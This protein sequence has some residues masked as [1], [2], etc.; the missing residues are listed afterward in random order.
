MAKR[1][2]LD[3]NAVI[4]F[5]NETEPFFTPLKKAILQFKAS[6]AEFYTSTIT[7]AEYMV[8]PLSENQFDKI[9]NYADF[10][11]EFE[12]QRLY[13]NEVV[14]RRS[15]EI[16]AKYRGIKLADALQLAASI[17]NECSAFLTNDRQLSQVNEAN[18]V[19][20]SDLPA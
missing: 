9:I 3:T 10:I 16:R 12:F 11:R 20:I 8:K 5:L 2:F 18:I 13:I 4:Y 7:D 19:L 14:A 15:A 6:G 17:V 1:I